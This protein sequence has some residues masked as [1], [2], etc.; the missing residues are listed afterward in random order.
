MSPIDD[1]ETT[2]QLNAIAW[3]FL[4]SEFTDQIYA[5]WPIDRRLDAF[6]LHYGPAALLSDGSAYNELLE[7]VMANIGA[8]LRRGVLSS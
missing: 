5:D 6:L 2:A 1:R 7:C 4:R 3:Q 8:A